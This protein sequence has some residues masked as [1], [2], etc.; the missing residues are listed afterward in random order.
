M[1]YKLISDENENVKVILPAGSDFVQTLY[2][3]PK[4]RA[5]LAA[6]KTVEPSSDFDGFIAVDGKVFIEGKIVAEKKAS[7]KKK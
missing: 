3:E 4:C 2:A 7:T 6:G 5:I 1:D